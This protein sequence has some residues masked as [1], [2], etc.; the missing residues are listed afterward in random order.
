MYAP[1]D[2]VLAALGLGL[3]LALLWRHCRG[4]RGAFGPGRRDG[5]VEKFVEGRC[6]ARG[7]Q[8]VVEKFTDPGACPMHASHREGFTPAT[9]KATAAAPKKTTTAPPKK[10][11]APV[12]VKCPA[13]QPCQKCQTCPPAPKCPPSK[14]WLWLTVGALSMGVVGGAWWLWRRRAA[15]GGGGGDDLSDLD[16]EGVDSPG[17]ADAKNAVGNMSDT[18]LDALL[19]E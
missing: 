3:A 6:V 2:C 18:E 10:T 16:L 13:C 19:K 4:W 8:R 7:A 12:V 5:F 9:K 15:G 14:A 17:T 11:A 1:I